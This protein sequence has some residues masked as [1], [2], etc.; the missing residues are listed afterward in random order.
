MNEEVFRKPGEIT[1]PNLENWLLP[2]LVYV[3]IATLITIGLAAFGALIWWLI[4]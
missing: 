3:G 4:F 2:I 1:D